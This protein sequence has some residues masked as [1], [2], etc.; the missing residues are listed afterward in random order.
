MLNQNQK[1]NYYI[2]LLVVT[3][4]IL[5]GGAGVFGK[6]ALAEI[7]PLSFTFLR[8]L[9]AS[10]FLIPFSLKYLPTFKRKD[11]KIILLSLLASA[12]VVL[13][14]FG[15]K[16]T[17]ANINQMIYT[18][19]PIVSALLSFYYLKERFGISKIIGIVVGF[20]GTVI[21]VLL[22]LI[23]DDSGGGTIGGNLTIVVAMLSISLYWVLSKKFHT[24]YSSLE[25]NNYF[26]FTTTI[27]LF[28]LSIFDLFGEPT[29]W[30]GVSTNAYLALIFVAILS[31]AIY[32]LIGQIIVKKATPVMAS[33]VL[34][35]QP[36]TTFIWA[37][38]FL[39]EKL[40]IIF[41]IGVFL[42]LLGVGIYNFSV[43]T[44]NS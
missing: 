30:Q 13:F 43:K 1:S 36:F 20:V 24:Q 27:L 17:T 22:P 11:Y 2:Y 15:I 5:G 26:I 42:S 8:F 32:Y 7:P 34:Y 14:S 37:Y 9:I 6:I 19:V 44:K 23:S 35:V 4:A 25:I 12:N 16:N 39:S 3:A 29:W 38:Y 41:L 18:A 28:F 33:M 21:V 40:S 31:T 10:I